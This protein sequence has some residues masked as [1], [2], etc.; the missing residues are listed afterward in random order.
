MYVGVIHTIQDRDGWTSM[1]KSIDTSA[2]P[3][4]ITLEATGTAEDVSRAVC[5]WSAPSVDLLRD[6]LNGM[7][8]DI[9][10][11]DCFAVPDEF[12]TQGVLGRQSPQAAGV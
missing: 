1:L 10:V 11:N 12:A 2:L 9:A 8:G 5:L 3:E 6:T 4:G 7:L